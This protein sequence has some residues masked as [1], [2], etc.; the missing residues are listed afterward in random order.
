MHARQHTHT[1]T[2]LLENFK[3]LTNITE[4]FFY[5]DKDMAKETIMGSFDPFQVAIYGNMQ[6][7]RRILRDTKNSTQARECCCSESDCKLTLQT[8]NIKKGEMNEVPAA[9]IAM[10]KGSGYGTN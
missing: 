4:T 8:V 2:K 3:L 9:F 6:G 5:T 1:S 7:T 10:I